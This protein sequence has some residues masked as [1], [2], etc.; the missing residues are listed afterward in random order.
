MTDHN[1]RLAEYIEY[2]MSRPCYLRGNAR[3]GS[4]ELTQKVTSAW[5]S[6]KI[7]GAQSLALKSLIRSL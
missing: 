7:T 5:Q 3:V 6:G 4:R 2:T 1:K